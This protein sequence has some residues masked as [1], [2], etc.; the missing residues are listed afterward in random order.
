MPA[1][2]VRSSLTG[3]PASIRARSS[4]AGLS[5]VPA[6][7]SSMIAFVLMVP[8]VPPLRLSFRRPAGRASRAAPVS[9]AR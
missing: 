8:P 3:T 6:V 5:S 2:T 1:R 9:E 7:R 4:L